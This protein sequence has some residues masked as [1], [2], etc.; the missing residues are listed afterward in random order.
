[1]LGDGLPSTLPDMATYVTLTL[2]QWIMKA[3]WRAASVRGAERLDLS[4]LKT[5]ADSAYGVHPGIVCT[6]FPQ[7]IPKN[8]RII[9]LLCMV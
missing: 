6:G 3:V 5:R 8:I 1:M 9:F 2:G 7:Y 4:Q